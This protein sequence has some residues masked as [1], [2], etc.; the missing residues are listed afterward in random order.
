MIGRSLIDEFQYTRTDYDN[1][2]VFSGCYMESDF[3]M[4]VKTDEDGLLNINFLPPEPPI[5][6]K[7]IIRFSILKRE[8]LIG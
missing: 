6:I 7:Y 4:A 8:H 5:V 2:L 3:T 1:E